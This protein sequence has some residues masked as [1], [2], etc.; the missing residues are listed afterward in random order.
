LFAAVDV[1]GSEDS[2]GFWLWRA[3]H[4]YQRLVDRTMVPEGLTHLQF[5]IL[6][7]VAWCLGHGYERVTQRDV[8]QRTT[9]HTAQISSVVKTLVAK[10]YLVQSRSTDDE[11]YRCLSLTDAGLTRLTSALPLMVATQRQLFENEAEFEALRSQLRR[12]LARWEA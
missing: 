2:L 10:G 4:E 8:A 12:L 11:R 5:V 3:A 9:V 7:V 6:T 1:K